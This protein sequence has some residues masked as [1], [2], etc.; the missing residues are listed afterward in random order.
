[1]NELKLVRRDIEMQRLWQAY[2]TLQNGCGKVCFV[3]GEAGLGKSVLL[4]MFIHELNEKTEETIIASS[5]CSIRSE[6]SIPYQPFKDILKQLVQEVSCNDDIEKKERPNKEKIKDALTFSARMLVEHA[7]NL[8]DNFIP[9]GAILGAVGKHLLGDEE[10]S[11]K[12]GVPDE[13]KVIEEYINTI[14][15]ISEK[16]RLVL[17]IDDLQ[18]IDNPSVNLLYQ[19]SVVLRH[20]PV[21][22]VGSYRDIDI[23]VLSDGE[24][25]PMHHLINEFKI[26]QGSVFIQL[27]ETDTNA[28]KMFMDSLLDREANIFDANFRQTLFERT[29][30]NPLFIHE[31]IC[32]LK[33]KGLLTSNELGIW[34]N[35]PITDWQSYPVRIEGIIQERIGRLEDSMLEILSQASVQGSRFIVQ[36]LS[37]TMGETSRDLLVTLSR[38]LQKQYHLVTEGACVRSE[39]GIMSEFNFSN[40]IFQQ[41]L[42]QELSATQRMLLH[43]DIAVILEDLFQDTLDDLAG[44]IARHYELAGE[45]AKALKYI[46]ITVDKMIGIAAFKEALILITKVLE[47][48]PIEIDDRIRLDYTIKQCLCFRST[49]GW[50]NQKTI[51]WYT[52]AEILSNKI[53]CFDYM[54]I[55]LFGQWTINLVKLDLVQCLDFATR[56]YKTAEDNPSLQ[57][58]LMS[59]ITL[60]NTYFWLGE[61][62][63]AKKYLTLFQQKHSIRAPEDKIPPDI[64]ILYNMFQLLVT[65]QLADYESTAKAKQWLLDTIANTKDRFCQCIAYQA[66]TWQEYLAGN[67]DKSGEYALTLL[68]LAQLGG[69][70]FY[71]AV[72]NMFYGIFVA[73]EN[74][75]KG[76]QQ[77][78]IGY[79]FLRDDPNEKITIMNS[80][81]GLL[82]YTAYLDNGEYN[83]IE[84][85]LASII[86]AAISKNEKCYLS[87]LYTLQ[88]RYYQAIDNTELKI[89]A[90][91]KAKAT[92]IQLESIHAEKILKKFIS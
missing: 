46:S 72:G 33:E 51:Y 89:E 19:L 27:N 79:D 68:D 57:M 29:D 75:D 78:Q 3:S 32:L 22:I 91:N 41:Y 82:L 60:I 70:P 65:F 53:S 66:L 74:L 85:G 84:N 30:G 4:D 69:Y 8:I 54:D 62:R 77:I 7:P 39:K 28:K 5:F 2:D 1:M 52:Q 44:D 92:A 47:Q 14:K 16:Y 35:N 43:G 13:S 67:Y 48:F 71:I 6:Y 55:I 76:I 87:E 37:R 73:S 26:D 24:K 38:T 64:E 10:K 49:K 31:M 81:Y 11:D 63:N 83:K 42:Y 20:S 59:L 40:Y 86:E 80:V 36:V 56:Y 12:Q 90:F 50:A 88:G 23:N 18:W 15:A 34:V 21:L 45:P 17:F 9:I 61:F 25:H 58:K